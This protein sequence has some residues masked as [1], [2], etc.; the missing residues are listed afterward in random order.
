[1]D[2][3]GIK[4]YKKSIINTR[5]IKIILKPK[6]STEYTIA[7]PTTKIIPKNVLHKAID[8]RGRSD[9]KPCSLTELTSGS[10]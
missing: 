7:K 8:S 6:P 9:V 10:A 1:M 2:N 4:K 5:P 3:N